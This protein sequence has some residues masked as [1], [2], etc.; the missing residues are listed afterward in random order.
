MNDAR[1]IVF[2][3]AACAE[4]LKVNASDLQGRVC[5]YQSSSADPIGLAGHSLCPPPEVFHGQSV[6][7]I[8]MHWLRMVFCRN[9][10]ANLFP[11]P[12]GMSNRFRVLVV[13]AASSLEVSD[14]SSAAGT[15]ST[16][17]DPTLD[18]SQLLHEAISQLRRPPA[19][20]RLPIRPAPRA[21]R[22]RR[23]RAA[24]VRRARKARS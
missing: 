10:V 7:G 18:E 1:K 8:I 20:V 23:P 24:V 3:N 6:T 5:S 9:D 15:G 14:T 22:A 4:W 13:V 21:R 12:A 11:W 17:S 19:R 16:N 2:V